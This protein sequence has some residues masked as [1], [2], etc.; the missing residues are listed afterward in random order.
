MHRLLVALVAACAGFAVATEPPAC[1]VADVPAPAASPARWADTVLDTYFVLPAGYAPTD[2]V[3]AGVAALEAAS[4]SRQL[5]RAILTEDLGALFEAAAEAGHPLAIQSAYRS[6]DYQ[7]RTFAYWVEQDGYDAALRTSARP[8]HSEHQLGTAIDL[9]SA[10][11]PPA[12]ELD[13][14]A[15]TPTGAWV[16]DNAWRFGFTMSYPPDMELASCYAYEP[17]HYR[18]LGRERAAE[19][20]ASGEPARLLLWRSLTEADRAQD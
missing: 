2:L 8:G 7:V 17:W 14:W 16:A 19:V 1:S 6:Y 10:D 11:G 13:D 4:E 20:H 9:R 5:V 12:W 18:Y 15:A 3:P